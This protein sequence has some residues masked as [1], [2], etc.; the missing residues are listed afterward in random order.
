M[1]PTMRSEKIDKTR[2]RE[3]DAAAPK[4]NETR[5]A[6]ASLEAEL[7]ELGRLSL[8][9]LRLRWRNYWGRLAPAPLSRSLLFRVM[10]YRLQARV[11]GDLDQKTIRL[12]DR[13]GSDEVVHS[14]PALR[15]TADLDVGSIVPASSVRRASDPL[16]LRPGVTLTREWKGSIERATVVNEGFAWNEQTYGSLSAV[17]FAIT[18][19]K[20]NGHR[21]FGVRPCDRVRAMVRKRGSDRSQRT[22]PPRPPIYRKADVP[23]LAALG[24]LQMPD[25]AI[26]DAGEEAA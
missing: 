3:S 23:P 13:L 19:T 21:F 24:P 18:G 4:H 10:A 17:A 25:G 22:L 1:S 11:F 15:T 7:A 6:G 16:I 5:R 20:W 8:D 12:L 9:D 26:V 2:R 14:A